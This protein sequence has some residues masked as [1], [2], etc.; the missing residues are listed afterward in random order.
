MKGGETLELA[1]KVDAIVFDKT[2]TLTRGKPAITDFSMIVTD[3]VFWNQV[4]K[5]DP[6]NG[7]DDLPFKGTVGCVLWL[8]ASLERNSEHLLAAAIVEHA[9]R[10]LE[11]KIGD[12]KDQDVEGAEIGYAQP[13]S[14]VAMTGRG[15]SGL[16]LESIDVAVGN[17]AFCECR[18]ILIS[19]EVEDSMQ[20]LERHGKTAIIAAVNGTIVVVMGVADELKPDAAA[21]VKYL[22]EHLGVDVWM[23]TGDNRRTARAISRQL[24]LPGDRVIAEALPVAKVEKVQ[25]LQEQGFVVGMVGDG[26][27]DSPA[28][29]EADVGLSMGTGAEIAAE[30]S[31]MVLVRSNVADVCTALDLSRVIFNRIKLNFLWSLLYNCLSIPLAAGV[32]YPMLH[33]RLP[34]T[35]AALAMALSSISVVTSSLSLRLYSPPNVGVSR[36]RASTAGRPRR[37]S[38]RSASSRRR[39]R[40]S[41]TNDDSGENSESLREPLLPRSAHRRSTRRAGNLSRMEEGEADPE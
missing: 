35:V 30:A 33:T 38:E 39:Q 10:T 27:N 32:F 1:S 41:S 24:N 20:R 26:V 19:Q 16:I 34:P 22:K 6:S 8:L 25:E 11:R 9:E 28:L 5:R 21:S 2:G 15:A 23:V 36:P 3:D 12:E 4:L 18:D 37:S 17:R 13:S 7:N 29:V 14:F 31:D 40:S